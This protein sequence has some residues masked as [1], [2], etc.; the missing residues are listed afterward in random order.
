MASYIM[1]HPPLKCARA[2][3]PRERQL[4]RS[5]C[6]TILRPTAWPFLDA[7][8]CICT[9]RLGRSRQTCVSL[10]PASCRRGLKRLRY[11]IDPRTFLAWGGEA[12]HEPRQ[13][14]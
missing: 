5:P 8:L 2:C 13:T 10:D 12:G 4:H 1:A 9:P 14:G 3:I 6:G 7:P 11:L